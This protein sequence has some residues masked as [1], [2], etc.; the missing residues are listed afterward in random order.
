[1]KQIVW[2][3]IIC[4]TE[5]GTYINIYIHTC[6]SKKSGFTCV[7]GTT[8]IWKHWHIKDTVTLYSGVKYWQYPTK[9]LQCLKI[10][11]STHKTVNKNYF[12]QLKYSQKIA[13]HKY[14]ILI[15]MYSLKKV[16]LPSHL[17]NL[18]KQNS[19]IRVTERKKK[20]PLGF[21]QVPVSIHRLTGK[22]IIHAS[23]RREH[24]S[25]WTIFPNSSGI[26]SWTS[27]LYI[28]VTRFASTYG[29]KMFLWSQSKK[30]DETSWR[31]EYV[32]VSYASLENLS[33]SFKK[34]IVL[35]I[36][37]KMIRFNL[38]EEHNLWNMVTC[39]L[40]LQGTLNVSQFDIISSPPLNFSS[41]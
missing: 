34:H 15:Y 17:G 27:S 26:I 21:L 13:I 41:L 14:D 24:Q 32:K 8:K 4:G 10:S 2:Q 12:T 20:D 11:T 39:F 25:F 38:C 33:F 35:W 31:C 6:K 22:S 23:T 16:L 28:M 9:Q 19:L 36:W 37:M 40:S 7:F 29:M 1:M 30:F 18:S 5:T 3:R